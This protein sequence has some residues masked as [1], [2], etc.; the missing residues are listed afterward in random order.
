[1]SEKEVGS[2]LVLRLL[3]KESQIDDFQLSGFAD[4]ASCQLMLILVYILYLG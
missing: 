4:V 1:M 2:E 3:Q